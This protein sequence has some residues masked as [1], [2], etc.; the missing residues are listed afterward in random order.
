MSED[1]LAEILV[2]YAN[3][4][5][6][7]AVNLKRQ[8]VELVNASEKHPATVPEQTT[9]NV[10]KFEAQKGP[11]LRDFETAEKKNNVEQNWNHALNILKSANATINNRFHGPNYVYSYWLY[12]D[13]IFRQK[14][15]QP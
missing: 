8:V 9:F 5:E 4:E 6:A 7:S 15:K 10:L 14:L 12:T 2:D 1:K 3:A 11:T 13:R